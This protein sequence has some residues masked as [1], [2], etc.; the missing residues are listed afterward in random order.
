M[1]FCST[2][3]CLCC[4][5]LAGTIL[6]GTQCLIFNCLIFNAVVLLVLLSALADPDQYHFSSSGLGGDFEL[7]DDA[8][9]CIA[10]AI[11]VLLVLIWAMAAHGACRQHVSRTI[12]LFC[13]HIFGFALKS[14]Y[15]FIQ[16]PSRNIH[17][18]SVQFSPSVVSDSL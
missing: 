11:S 8:N 10:I 14:L 13:Y 18:S 4:H 7:M 2:S 1:P 3:C 9:M 17:N 15:L 12:P 16:I 6:L 5:V